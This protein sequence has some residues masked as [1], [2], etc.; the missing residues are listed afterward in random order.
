MPLTPSSSGQMDHMIQQAS[1][2]GSSSHS[3]NLPTS[4]SP[5]PKGRSTEIIPLISAVFPYQASSIA[6]IAHSLEIVTPP[7]HVLEGFILDHPSRG[8]TVYVHLP[9]PH[10]STKQQDHPLPANFS[11]VLRPHIPVSSSSSTG[12]RGES[13]HNGGVN[14]LP[15]ALDVR[16]SITALLDL[17]SESLFATN[18]VLVLDKDDRDPEGLRGL[19]HALMYVGGGLIKEG[20]VDGGYEWDTRR[21]ALVGIEL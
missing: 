13:R 15:V 18:L 9:P 6:Q 4:E 11:E 12:E 14:A 17:A 21:W 8:R 20:A 16:D 7:D 2:S 10:Q 1:S 3:D 19:L 5:P